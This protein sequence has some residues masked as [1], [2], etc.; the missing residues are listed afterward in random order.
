MIVS[1]KTR[2][3]AAAAFL[4]SAAFATA[5]AQTV[6]LPGGLYAGIDAGIMIPQSISWHASGTSAGITFSGSGDLNL[7][8]GAA[9]GIIVGYR[10]SPWVALEGNFEYAGL[11]LDSITGSGTVSGAV[12]ASGSFKLGLKGHIDTYNGLF[13][14]LF[15][16][17]ANQGFY[18]IAPYVGAGVGFSNIHGTLDSVSAGGAT[19]IVNASG[20]E[21][22]FA[23]NGILGFDVGVMPNLT[24]GARYRFLYVNVG[25]AF[26]GDGLAASSG[27][28]FG[29]VISANATWHF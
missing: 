11:E 13:N 14:A 19:A 15:Y 8:P 2:V 7:N 25:S 17:Y 1:F 27:D 5:D 23:A 4:V 22:D 16:P 20:S 24:V 21:T 28:F 12:A 26:A 3:F 29:H 6:A 9:A 18:G 10:F